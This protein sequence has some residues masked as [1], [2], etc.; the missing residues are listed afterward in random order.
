M[1]THVITLLK[2]IDRSRFEIALAAP[3][4]MERD[5]LGPCSRDVEFYPLELAESGGPLG[6]VYRSVQ[7]ST[8]LRQSRFDI[9]HSHGLR[10]T[11]ASGLGGAAA[12]AR[13]ATLH[14]P[15]SGFSS[16]ARPLVSYAFKAQTHCIA[17]SDALKRDIL[18]LGVP[19]DQVCVIPNGVGAGRR[20]RAEAQ[21]QLASLGLD[22][23]ERLILVCARFLP[24]DIAALS[25]L[26]DAVHRYAQPLRLVVCGVGQQDGALAQARAE[27][28]ERGVVITGYVPDLRALF[29]AAYAVVVMQPPIAL[30]LTVLEAMAEAVPVVACAGGEMEE[31]I[32]DGTTGYLLPP[33]DWDAM[34]ERIAWL[35]EYPDERERV[36][37]AARDRIVTQFSDRVSV[38]KLEAL[39][40]EVAGQLTGGAERAAV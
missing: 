14:N 1:R 9:L 6:L 38:R 33:G 12:P 21:S 37:A 2:H 28:H 25:A 13:I 20:T 17:L 27:F 22:N 23:S 26:V 10:A 24:S 40:D 29:S 30:P 11:T 36:G 31:V 3:S 35:L 19:C 7:L 18:A 16:V 34:A 39:Y 5:L 8:L 15:L 4:N 32:L